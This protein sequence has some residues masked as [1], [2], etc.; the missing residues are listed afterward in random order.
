MKECAPILIVDDNEDVRE[1]F[2]FTL[3]SNGYEVVCASDGGK[4]LE[5]L[6]TGLRPCVIVLDLYMPGLDGFE[7]RAEQSADPALATIPTII[8][9]GAFNATRA[10]AALDAAAAFRK[11]VDLDAMVAAIERFSQRGHDA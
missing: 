3:E 8:I 7:F 9:S 2:A 5:M 6:R 11:P 4:A 1:M 10:G